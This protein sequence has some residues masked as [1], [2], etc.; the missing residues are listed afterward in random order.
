MMK[1]VCSIACAA[2]AAGLW[3]EK[4]NNHKLRLSHYSMLVLVSCDMQH[5]GWTHAICK[6]YN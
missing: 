5:A 4:D 1:Y 2:I 3:V 6:Y